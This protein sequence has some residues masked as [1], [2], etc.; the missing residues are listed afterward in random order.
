[1]KTADRSDPTRSQASQSAREQVL[2]RLELILRR[3]LKLG[4][5]VPIK[6]TTPLIGGDHDL[7]SLDVLMLVTS[8]EKEF[9]IKIPNDEVKRDI[10]T[11][12][13]SLAEYIDGRRR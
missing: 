13:G 10:F 1:M 8:V 4:D 11:N 5:D 3:D 7:D 2:K 6:A 9:N 12:V